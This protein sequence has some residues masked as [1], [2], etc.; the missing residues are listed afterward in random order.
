MKEWEKEL[1]TLTRAYANTEKWNLNGWFVEA[2]HR[3]KKYFQT[4]ELKNGDSYI[5]LMDS[6]VCLE[7][8]LYDKYSEL[9]EID[10][11][12]KISPL[13]T[14]QQSFNKELDVLQGYSMSLKALKGG[15]GKPYPPQLRDYLKK[16]SSSQVLTFE[17]GLS[18]VCTGRDG[19]KIFLKEVFKNV[20]RTTDLSAELNGRSFFIDLSYREDIQKFYNLVR[21]RS[22]DSFVGRL[23]VIDVSWQRINAWTSGLDSRNSRKIELGPVELHVR[24][25]AISNKLKWTDENGKAVSEENVKFLAAWLST[26]PVV[27]EYKRSND[28]YVNRYNDN[29]LQG[30]LENAYKSG[31]YDKAY[32]LLAAYCKKNGQSL[33]V[34]TKSYVAKDSGYKAEAFIFTVDGDEPAVFKATFENNDITKDFSSIEKSSAKEFIDFCAEKYNDTY[35]NIKNDKA[36]EIVTTHKDAPEW[37]VDKI[38]S[39]LARWQ[40]G[41]LEFEADIQVS[42]PEKSFDAIIES[43]KKHAENKREL[44]IRSEKHDLSQVYR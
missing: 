23:E 14:K 31:D 35:I 17:N 4:G 34:T 44:H 32:K 42:A 40:M 7:L 26:A 6:G 21:N 39:D 33:K 3:M 28:D 25:S 1:E 9:N 27:T 11:D 29:A 22:T 36:L 8:R 43:Y 2:D 16:I 24:K 13:V 19:D 37:L 10:S 20:T 38:S 5:L 15:I 30:E 41:R 18:F 12:M